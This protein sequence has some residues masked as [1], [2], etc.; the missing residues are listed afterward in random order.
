MRARNI[1]LLMCAA[2]SVDGESNQLS[3][4]N[5]IENLK[6]EIDANNKELPAGRQMLVPIAFELVSFW[7]FDELKEKSPITAVTTFYGPDG[8]KLGS[9]E[10]VWT[11]AKGT[12]GWRLRMGMKSL[13]VIASGRYK[14]VVSIGNGNTQLA[15]AEYDFEVTL[16]RR[17]VVN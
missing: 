8:E 16:M 17:D 12:K 15:E 5:I 10:N 9:S 14:H 13:P 7:Q 2:S 3:I 6:V 4:F 1:F 11:L